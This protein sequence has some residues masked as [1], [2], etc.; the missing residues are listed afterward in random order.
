MSAATL[1]AGCSYAKLPPK[2]VEGR[3]FSVATA[4]RLPV[5][6]SIGAVITAL[7][8]PL[9]RLRADD[10][11]TWRYSFRTEQKEIV[12]LLGIIPIPSKENGGTAVATLTF[13]DERLLSVVVSNR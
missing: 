5:G 2:F 9:D 3:Q 1:A 7:G 13:R 11:E 6:S 10:I 8:E 12:R 4:R